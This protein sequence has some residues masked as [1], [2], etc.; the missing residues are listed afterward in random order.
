[1]SSGS[2]NKFEGSSP[3]TAIG[4]KTNFARE[5]FFVGNASLHL[6]SRCC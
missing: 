5:S 6:L 3:E 1:M 4:A 2:K